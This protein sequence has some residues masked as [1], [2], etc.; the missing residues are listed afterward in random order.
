[1]VA[2]IRN[3]YL[4]VC[5]NNNFRHEHILNGFRIARIQKTASLLIFLCQFT[6]VFLHR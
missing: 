5:N 4:K 3:S 1:M 6:S 2:T